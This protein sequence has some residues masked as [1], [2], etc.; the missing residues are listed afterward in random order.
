MIYIDRQDIVAVLELD[1]GLSMFY[2]LQDEEAIRINRSEWI[3]DLD[4]IQDILAQSGKALTSL[5][6]YEYNGEKTGQAIISPEHVEAVVVSKIHDN[7]TTVCVEA[8]IDG[9][10]K[11]RSFT[12]PVEEV[13]KFVEDVYALVL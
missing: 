12:I 3:H 1:Q 10:G 7:D 6:L 8:Y 13:K 9:C 5:P 4:Y 11:I 2:T